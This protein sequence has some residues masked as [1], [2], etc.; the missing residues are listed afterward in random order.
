MRP[1]THYELRIQLKF[2]RPEGQLAA[3]VGT[4]QKCLSELLPLGLF[5]LDLGTCMLKTSD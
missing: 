4:M 1:L 3:Y 2:F 5:K